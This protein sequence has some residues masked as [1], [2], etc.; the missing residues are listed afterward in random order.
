METNDNNII[1]LVSDTPRMNNRTLMYASL[2]LSMESY[3]HS[4]HLPVNMGKSS[5]F[6]NHIVQN[7]SLDWTFDIE[8]EGVRDVDGFP[9][10][11]LGHFLHRCEAASV[12]HSGAV[13]NIRIENLRIA[14]AQAEERYNL[15][16][17]SDV[18][19]I[20]ADTLRRYR[21]SIGRF[22]HYRGYIPVLSSKEFMPTMG[23]APKIAVFSLLVP[24]KL[25]LGVR[26]YG[27][28]NEYVGLLGMMQNDVHYSFY[29]N[30]AEEARK[31]YEVQK[32]RIETMP[33]FRYSL[34]EG[35]KHYIVFK[36]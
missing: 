18:G 4:H 34:P 19:S 28:G 9:M 6:G 23:N 2:L 12:L 29:Y 16:C 22:G 27:A 8:T 5:Y 31:E 1:S 10:V 21:Q 14:R 36:A 17:G 3:K 30:G 24:T 20:T 33:R 32:K 26:S 25:D 11:G 15:R 7:P 35:E 13:G